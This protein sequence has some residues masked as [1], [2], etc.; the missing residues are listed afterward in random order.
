MVVADNNLCDVRKKIRKINIIR[1]LI[2][3]L[4]VL[5]TFNQVLTFFILKIILYL[6]NFCTYI[7]VWYATVDFLNSEK[8]FFFQKL[9]I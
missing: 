1:C 3:N 9:K 4:C 7:L 8:L 2:R 5:V 6:S